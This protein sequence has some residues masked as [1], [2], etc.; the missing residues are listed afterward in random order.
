MLG[1]MSSVPDIICLFREHNVRVFVAHFR[2]LLSDLDK[3]DNYAV[4]E[5]VQ[6][7][8][9]RW[10]IGW[11]FQDARLPDV[12]CPFPS[13]GEFSLGCQ[14]LDFRS[15][16][17]PNPAEHHAFSK[18]VASYVLWCPI[19]RHFSKHLTKRARTY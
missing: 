7:Q 15:H 8:T 14:H 3:V 5:F 13:Y 11:S 12:C 1:K 16:L 2:G 18:H 6:G 10:A 17:E 19:C 4:T 9:R